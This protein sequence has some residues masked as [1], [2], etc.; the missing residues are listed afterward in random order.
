MCSP[1]STSDAWLGCSSNLCACSS[2]KPSASCT[3]STSCSV[4]SRRA[5]QS[6]ASSWSSLSAAGKSSTRLDSSSPNKKMVS[7]SPLSTDRGVSLFNAARA[8]EGGR[9]VGQPR[10]PGSAEN[11]RPRRALGAAAR[12][13]EFSSRARVVDAAESRATSRAAWTS[14]CSWWRPSGRRTD[15]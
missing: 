14:A 12:H 8:S 9:G 13:S 15:P 7:I 6:I 3:A 5:I 4:G 11:L 1:V 2:A 10:P